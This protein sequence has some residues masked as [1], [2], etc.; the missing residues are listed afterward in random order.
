MHLSYTG[1]TKAPIQNFMV[2]PWKNEYLF[3]IETTVYD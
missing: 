1:I 2:A 3:K